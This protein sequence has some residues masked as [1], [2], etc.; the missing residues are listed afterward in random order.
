VA[1][2]PPWD[3]QVVDFAFGARLGLLAAI[4]VAIACNGWLSHR[5]DTAI[6]AKQAATEARAAA[7]QASLL[8]QA[9]RMNLPA[10]L[11]ASPTFDGIDCVHQDPLHAANVGCWTSFEA[12]AVVQSEL[13]AALT[14]EGASNLAWQCSPHDWSC[15]GRASYRDGQLLVMITSSLDPTTSAVRLLAYLGLP[16]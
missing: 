10:G 3:S 9:R 13:T 1:V 2:Q 16:V 5:A 8:S 4:A 15:S 11:V 6:A 12:V 7:D 14:T